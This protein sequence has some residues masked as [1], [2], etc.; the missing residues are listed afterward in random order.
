MKILYLAN[1]YVGKKI[2]T[3][4]LRQKDVDIVG[5]VV[6]PAGRQKFSNEIID[7]SRMSP[8][9]IFYADTLSDPAT[10]HQISDLRPDIAISV[11]FGY[12]LR[13]EFLSIFPKGCINLH[14][15]Y[16]PWNRGAYPNVWSIVDQTPAGATLHYVNEM[17]DRGDIIARKEIPVNAT[18]TGYTLYKKLEQTSISLFKESWPNLQ[19]GQIQRHC[20]NEEEGSYHRSGDVIGIDEIDLEKTYV[21]KDLL[22]IIRSRTFPFC[23]GAFFIENGEK[24]YIRIKFLTEDECFRS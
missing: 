6:H 19:S 17:V 21:A 9:R 3:W 10:L 16:L 5:L 22:N 12:I 1:N 18:D 4:L 20:Q 23:T 11:Y 24:K 15:A 14:P 2:L 7:E 13:K 8:D